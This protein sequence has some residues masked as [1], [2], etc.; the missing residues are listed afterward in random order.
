[1]NIILFSEGEDIL[2]KGDPRSD[3]IRRVL[4]LKAGDSFRA[5]FINGMQGMALIEA[6]DDDEI[7]LSFAFNEDGSALYP[8]TMII[9][10]VRP[11]CMKRIL[12]EAVSLGV[13][14]LILPV[15]DL[16]EKS[17][18]SSSLYQKGEYKDILLDG[19]MQAG[20]TGIP[21]TDLTPSLDAAIAI[22]KSDMKIMLDNVIGSV[23]LSSLSLSGRK[24][25]LAVGP[26]R[27]WSSRERSL[28]LSSG[29]RPC[30]LGARILRTETAAGCSA[31]VA[32]SRMGI[33]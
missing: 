23:P 9:A 25:S 26:E 32:L 28:L 33:L 2:R 7:R 3:H 29:Y 31:A 21:E 1:M 20:F 22:D 24:V 5:G 12:R 30:L 8:I 6:M 13:G 16:G 10:Q 11:I 19:A 18:L 4:K 15:S 17:Y 14:K 27:G